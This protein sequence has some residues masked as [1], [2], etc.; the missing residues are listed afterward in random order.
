VQ[1]W[2]MKSEP[3]SFSIADLERV[4]VEPWSG[5]RNRMARNFMRKMEVGDLVLFYHSST[6]PPGV[7]GIASVERTNV[8]DETQFDPASPY[9]D[10]DAKRESPTWDCV[11]VRYVGRVPYYVSLNRMRH[12]PE[13][14]GM[15]VLNRGRLSV[16]PVSEAHYKRVIE[17]G[18]IDAPEPPKIVKPRPKPKK[19]KAKPK[20]KTNATRRAKP[21]ARPRGGRAGRRRPRSR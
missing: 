3:D 5:V 9:F 21:A 18:D 1:Y 10:A 19:K 11:D 8:V 2:L 15:W 4:Q 7:A 6:E 14:A 13:L 16:Q 17:L 12:D 20:A